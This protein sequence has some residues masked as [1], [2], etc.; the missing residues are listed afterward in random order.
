MVSAFICNETHIATC[1][2]L[3]GETLSHLGNMT[4]RGIAA[5]LAE[6]NLASVRFRYGED[7][8]GRMLPES[9]EGDGTRYVER[10]RTAAALPCSAAEGYGYLTCLDYQSCEH[11][12]WNASNA[13]RWICEA[14]DAL[15]VAMREELL[16]GREV[17]ETDGTPKPL[18][19]PFLCNPVHIA[20]CAANLKEADIFA[21]RNLFVDGVAE[22][23]GRANMAALGLGGAGE[24]AED[25]DVLPNGMTAAQY[26]HECRT[27]APAKAGPAD[28]YNFLCC[29]REQCGGV[30]NTKAVRWI[31]EGLGR[32]EW[33]LHKALV[34]GA[35]VWEAPH[36]DAETEPVQSA[37]TP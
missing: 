14:R 12:G 37:P 7:A 8:V 16:A 23:L 6:Q 3:I 25:G 34:G 15:V 31:D 20:T 4:P 22:A 10:C 36:G 13:R 26:L 21:F 17:W 28:I 1:A 35:H 30:G 32:Q 24:E 33:N 19:E 9:A 11:P 29:L 27:A 18:P 2:N 5:Q